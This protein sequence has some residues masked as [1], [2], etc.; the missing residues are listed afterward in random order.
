MYEPGSWNSITTVTS[1]FAHGSWSHV[2]GNLFFFF[3]FSATLKII[4]GFLW[5]PVVILFIAFG[6]NI[7]YS[8]YSYAQTDL[9]PTLG[10]SGVVMGVMAMLVLFLPRV[11]IRFFFWLVLIIWRFGLPAWLVVLWYLGFDTYNLFAQE[12]MGA[13]NLVAHVTGAAIGYGLGVLFFRDKRDE[14]VAEYIESHPEERR[15]A[16][17]RQRR[18]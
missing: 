5:Y 3:A 10:L 11:E 14:V 12:Q 9:L 4:L 18:R 7:F 2:I 13:I 15:K 6:T 8:L 17:R 16:Y 1:T